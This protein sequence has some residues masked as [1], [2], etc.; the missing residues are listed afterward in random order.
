VHEVTEKA[1]IAVLGPP[2]TRHP[3]GEQFP[4]HEVS[5]SDAEAFC[6]A[7]GLELPTQSQW[8]YACRAGSRGEFSGDLE[9]VAWYKANSGGSPHAVCQKKPN[10]F[11]LHDMHGNVHE[12]C[13]DAFDP[14]V[15]LR[16]AKPERD[17]VGTVGLRHELRGGGCESDPRYCR[18]AAR[19]ADGA[20]RYSYVGFRPVLD[21]R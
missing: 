8:E 1:W 18:S 15:R 21:F 9:D 2:P 5:W 12:W 3:L 19:N 14:N 13:R 6:K 10:D 11:G 17:P 20:S 4:V 7:T 16:V